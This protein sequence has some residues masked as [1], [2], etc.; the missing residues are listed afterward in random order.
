MWFYE[1]QRRTFSFDNIEG[2]VTSFEARCQRQ[3]IKG[4]V[5]SDREWELPDDWGSCQVFVFG[6]DGATFDF[7]GHMNDA[8]DSSNEAVAWR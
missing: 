2:E 8:N 7:L 5:T 6:D 1:P 4:E 3:R